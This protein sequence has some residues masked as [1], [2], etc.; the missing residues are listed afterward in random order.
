MGDLLIQ[1]L[2]IFTEFFSV[3]DGNDILSPLFSP[4]PLTP[5]GKKIWGMGIKI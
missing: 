2:L 1:K 5:K 4:F 3:N